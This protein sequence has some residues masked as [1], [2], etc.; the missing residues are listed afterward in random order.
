MSAGK[1]LSAGEMVLC[2]R[3]SVVKKSRDERQ[4]ERLNSLQAMFQRAC[5][6]DQLGV[7]TVAR[8]RL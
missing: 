4:P 5:K 8:K 1:P 2:L 7:A 3:D 6:I